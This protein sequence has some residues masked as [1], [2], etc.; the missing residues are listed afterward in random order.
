MSVSCF[1]SK[2]ELEFNLN[3]WQQFRN[4][5]LCVVQLL[6][7]IAGSFPIHTVTIANNRMKLQVYTSEIS[8]NIALKVKG[9]DEFRPCN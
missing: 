7:Y 1:K 6:H 4:F 3:A 5:A 8:D 2:S 9:D